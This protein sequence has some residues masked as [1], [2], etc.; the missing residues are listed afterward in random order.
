M[1]I[2]L[3]G[4]TGFI[5]SKLL[6]EALLRGHQITALVSRPEK[7][8]SHASI[9]AVRADVL[10]EAALVEQ[11]KG[12][13]VVISAFSGH[14]QPN[15]YDYYMQGFRSILAAVKRAEVPRFL[16]V[17]GA[18]SLEVAPGVQLVDTPEFPAQWKQSAE[19]ARQALN[20]LRQ[21]SR[22]DWTML[23]PAAI[24]EPGR[25]TGTYRLGADQLIVDERGQSRISVEDY[26]AAMMD[27]VQSHASPRRRITVA[28]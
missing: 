3:I 13:D 7:V 16:V 2:A 12:H 23:S 4:A 24:I 21:E 18:G 8:R 20:L 22:L 25:R 19:G 9:K 14:A 27:E 5:G 11:L 1:N 10:D 17:G 26:A 28:Y 15:V 6:D